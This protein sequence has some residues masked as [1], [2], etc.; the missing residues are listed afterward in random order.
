MIMEQMA[1]VVSAGI[2]ERGKCHKVQGL[3]PYARSALLYV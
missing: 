1:M 3:S 2:P